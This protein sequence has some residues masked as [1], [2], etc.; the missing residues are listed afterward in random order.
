MTTGI[1]AIGLRSV[2]PDAR[3]DFWSDVPAEDA[4]LERLRPERAR[5]LRM[6][7]RRWAR[8]MGLSKRDA[9][10]IQYPPEVFAVHDAMRV[11][12]RFSFAIGPDL[13]RVGRTFT[14]DY[15]EGRKSAGRLDKTLQ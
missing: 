4:T 1:D 14:S 6:L 2:C 15:D 8:Q 3:V 10:V 11:N 12:V 13:S 7:V 9:F 5:L